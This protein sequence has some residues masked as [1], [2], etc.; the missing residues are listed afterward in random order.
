MIAGPNVGLLQESVSGGYDGTLDRTFQ[1]SGCAHTPRQRR[2][3]GQQHGRDGGAYGEV[4]PLARC[5]A[6]TQGVTPATAPGRF[7]VLLHRQDGPG[8][9]SDLLA[10]RD[11]YQ[12][13]RRVG[14]TF[15]S[16][17]TNRL[18]ACHDGN[19]AGLGGSSELSV[20]ERNVRVR[21]ERWPPHSLALIQRF[22]HGGCDRSAGL[23]PRIDLARLRTSGYDD[24]FVLEK[25]NTHPLA[26]KNLRQFRRECRGGI[27]KG[28]AREQCRL[29]AQHGIPRCRATPSD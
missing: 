15:N 26:A 6:L 17:R 9:R 3:Q 4:T 20:R 2:C 10:Q 16:Q 28:P 7:G 19:A 25:A 29:A 11:L 8:K 5:Q 27:S 13:Q 21:L 1:P 14:A 23:Q 24:S 18:P 22:V 12:C